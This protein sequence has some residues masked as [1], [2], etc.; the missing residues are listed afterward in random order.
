MQ[1][2]PTK[3]YKIVASISIGLWEAKE[4]KGAAQGPSMEMSSR[5][6]LSVPGLPF[7]GGVWFKKQ[8]VGPGR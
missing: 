2:N 5:A 1:N 6:E 3:C 8:S 4:K 7:W